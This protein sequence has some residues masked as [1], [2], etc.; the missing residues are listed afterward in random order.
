MA[1]VKWIKIVTDIFDDEKVLLIEG[2]PEADGIIV[3]WF[4]LLCLAGKQNNNGVFMMNDKLPYTDEMLATIFRRPL[5]LVRLALTTF[6]GFGM[7][8]IIDDV[9]T[10]PN[11]EKHQNIEGLEKIKEQT[12]KRVA[13]YRER[14][15]LVTKNVTLRNAIEKNI[16]ED[17]EK[18]KNNKKNNKKEVSIDSLIN[19]FSTDEK[20]RNLLNDWLAVRKQKRA[21]NTTRA[22]ELNLKK[23]VECAKDSNME[24]NEYL[25]EVIMRGWQAFYVINNNKPITKQP[26]EKPTKKNWYDV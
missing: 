23:L 18:D 20:T 3:I 22:I 21:A 10:I 15:K 25:E 12:R 26:E 8:E 5:N 2:L 9:I 17:K 11:W 16:E 7:I 6:E 1:E 4:K 24:I 19:D 13:A 14:Q